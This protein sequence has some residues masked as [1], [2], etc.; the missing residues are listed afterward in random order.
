MFKF[1][2]GIIVGIVTVTYYPEIT[3]TLADWFV[4]SGSRDVVVK[5]L[6]GM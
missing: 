5:T 1:V 2:F 3:I 6:E 4:E